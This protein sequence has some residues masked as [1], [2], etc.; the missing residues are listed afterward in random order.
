MFAQDAPARYMPASPSGCSATCVADGA[1]MIG[2]LHL[3][4]EDLRRQIDGL[5]ID[6][7]ARHQIDPVERLPITTQRVL[8][9]IAVRRVVVCGLRDVGE[10]H[11]LEVERDE[12]LVQARRALVRRTAAADPAAR[13]AAASRRPRCRAPASAFRRD[14]IGLPLIFDDFPRRTSAFDFVSAVRA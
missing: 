7:L 13:A 3:E 11:R 2:I 10:H 5:G 14:M 4:V 1:M 8:A 12:H 9:A 6:G